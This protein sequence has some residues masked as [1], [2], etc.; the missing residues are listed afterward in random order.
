MQ[1]MT[2]GWNSFSGG[3]VLALAGLGFLNLA[4]AADDGTPLAAGGA[5]LPLTVATTGCGVFDRFRLE[6]MIQAVLQQMMYLNAQQRYEDI[7][8]LL[9][10]ALASMEMQTPLMHY[11]LACAR[12]LLGKTE[13]A[14]ESLALAVGGGFAWAD[15]MRNDRDLVTLRE[16]PR[17]EA[18]LEGVERNAATA[19]APMRPD[20]HPI[21]G[22]VAAVGESNT[23]WVSPL[24]RFLVFHTPPTDADIPVVLL[25]DNRD[26]DHSPMNISGFPQMARLV[27]AEEAIRS[28]VDYNAQV[29][30]LHNMP[31]IGNASLSRVEVPLWRSLTRGMYSQAPH[32]KILADQY[33]NSHLYVYPEHR[34]HDPDYGDVFPANT[35]YVITSQGSSGS[36]QPFL[37][38]IAG[39]LMSFRPETFTFL[40]TQGLLMSSVQMIFRA[41]RTP[42]PTPEDYLTGRAHPA[43]FAAETLDVD[44]M[45]AMAAAFEYGDAPPVVRLEVED[46]DTA[47]P[48]IDYFEVVQAERLFDTV[49]A[50]ARVARASR[51]EHRLVVSAAK[52]RDPNGRPLTFQWRLLRGDETR[53][54]IRMLNVEGTR[55][56]LRVRWHERG[57]R[58]GDE[59][60]GT[61][62]DIGIFAHNGVHYSAPA[63]VTWY[64][65]A[66]EKRAYD[67]VGRISSIEYLVP[68][69]PESYVDPAVVT[70]ADWKDVYE[71]APNGELLGW[72]RTRGEEVEFFGRDGALVLERDALG[73]PT[74]ARPVGYERL[75]KTMNDCPVLRQVPLPGTLVYTYATDDDIIGVRQ[76]GPDAA[77]GPN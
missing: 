25:Y 58:A 35:P 53:V 19:T 44:R 1:W 50:I 26:R 54:E 59:I 49:S 47:V 11:N 76:R 8:R 31:T 37:Q 13:S 71:Y 70:P 23:L 18:L 10:G 27:Y 43:V 74:L 46:E 66:N 15:H 16:L 56:E 62:V 3:L 32:M 24:Q 9:V 29:L 41:C 57:I 72:Y 77:T 73:R 22:G 52:T 60:P 5:E 36:D 34:D 14:L 20:P 42:I 65:P 12:A 67:E 63:F 6:G 28:G 45:K 61:R 38:A 51:R 64:F 21:R 40:A 30:F 4:Q 7:E 33:L 39:T 17:F 69:A 68:S 2:C 75:Q 48:G 55:A